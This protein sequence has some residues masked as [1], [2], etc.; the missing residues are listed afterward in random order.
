M[1]KNCSRESQ[2]LQIFGSQIAV[3][4]HFKAK[5]M[6]PLLLIGESRLHAPVL[7]FVTESMLSPWSAYLHK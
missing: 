7:I 2:D 3:S 1:S 6:E 5:E 4:Y